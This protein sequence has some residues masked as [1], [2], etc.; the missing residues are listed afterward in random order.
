L[1]GSEPAGAPAWYKCAW[2]F[3]VEKR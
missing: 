3:K 1:A 2:N